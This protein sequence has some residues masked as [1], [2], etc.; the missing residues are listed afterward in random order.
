M[1]DKTHKIRV[2]CDNDIQKI[3]LTESRELFVQAVTERFQMLTAPATLTLETEDGTSKINDEDSW[4]DNVWDERDYLAKERKAVIHVSV[5]ANASATTSASTAVLPPQSTQSATQ[6]ATAEA[7]HLRREEELIDGWTCARRHHTHDVFI[8]Y[9][10]SGNDV[11]IAEKLAL[12]ILEAAEDQK[13]DRLPQVYLDKKCLEVGKPW[14]QGF[15]NG[16]HRSKV[17]VFTIS[18][19]AIKRVLNA[20]KEDDNMLLEWERALMLLESGKSSIRAIV[21]LVVDNLENFGGQV[22]TVKYKPWCETFPDCKPRHPDSKWPGTVKSLMD[23][24]FKMQTKPLNPS[25]PDTAIATILQQWSKLNLPENEGKSAALLAVDRALLRERLNPVDGPLEDDLRRLLSEHLPGTRGWLLDEI[26]KWL[27]DESDRAF[28]IEGGAGVGKSVMAGQVIKALRSRNSLGAFF[29]CKH[30]DIHRNDARKLVFTVASQLS[31]WSTTFGGILSRVLRENEDLN[32]YGVPVIFEMLIVK[33]LRELESSLQ[34]K[35]STVV[36]VIDALDECGDAIGRSGIL[37]ALVEFPKLPNFVKLLVTSRPESDI[38]A[39]L[40]KH[41]KPR[42]LEPDNKA[43]KNDVRLFFTGL[44]REVGVSGGLLANDA[45]E[46]LADKSDG[47][48]IWSRVVAESLRSFGKPLTTEDVDGVTEGLDDLY[49]NSLKRVFDDLRDSDEATETAKVLRTIVTLA[50]PLSVA[51]I[52][53]IFGFDATAAVVTLGSI[54]RTDTETRQVRVIHKS[55]VDYLCSKK[56]NDVRYFVDVLESNRELTVH[57]LHVLNTQ[58]RYNMCGLSQGFRFSQASYQAK[59]GLSL[60]PELEYSALFLLSHLTASLNSQDHKQVDQE[61]GQLLHTLVQN[62][63]LFWVEAVALV[64]VLPIF[65]AELSTCVD[66][67]Q[68]LDQLSQESA[69]FRDLHRLVSEFF[70][71]INDSPLSIYFSA[72]PWIPEDVSLRTV[73]NAVVQSAD[74]QVPWLAKNPRGE[75]EYCVRTLEG[76]TDGVLS[77]AVSRDGKWI[78]SGSYDSTIKVWDAASGALVRT[79]E[80][81]TNF[82]NSVAVSRDGK[83][84][85]SGSVDS[86]VNVWDAA[87][88]ALVRTLEGHTDPVVSVAVSQDGKWIVSGSIDRTV[89][90]WDTTNGALLRTLEGHTNAVKSVAVSRDGK[91]IV[92]GSIDRTVK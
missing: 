28:W 86:T 5:S 71:A 59:Q 33:P 51:I 83:W 64:K 53:K 63:I 43:N 30:D 78:V 20:C 18:A 44:V 19:N 84:I 23:E 35:P 69:V 14:Q 16:L 48:F 10:A 82:V 55:I 57:C 12:Q 79:L 37:E 62:K 39:R 68:T 13:L 3:K 54:L 21:P 8:S 90:V 89:K 60:L 40:D 88:G 7:E 49:A 85:V 52:S 11:N 26:L 1:P 56:C 17:V 61:L 66:Q 24:I 34:M 73:S 91:W 6:S 46:T 9:R 77:V 45:V 87:S 50:R 72:V 74:L 67:L 70:E 76:H 65:V 31:E 47:L 80:G 27:P 38:V 36:I 81:H 42:R 22:G 2:K 25:E 75:W 29:I 15:L 92:S 4:V 41:F 32:I 58:L